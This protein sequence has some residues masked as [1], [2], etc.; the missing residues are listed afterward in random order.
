MDKKLCPY[1]MSEAVE[2]D[3]K[4]AAC[5]RSI[6]GYAPQP[7][8]LPPGWT[9]AGRYRLGR[10]LGEGGFGV[11][12]LEKDA[13]LEVK[14]AIKEYFPAQLIS[15]GP[16]SPEVVRYADA[17]GLFEK[18]RERFLQEARALA[19]ME[20][21]KEIVG[22]SGYF[23]ENGTAYIVM[24]LVEGETFTALAERQ[25][26]RM[27]GGQLLGLVEPLLLSLGRMHS[28]GLI[29]RDISPD[30][31]MLEDGAVR[32]LDMGSAKETLG[33][34]G[35]TATVLLKH[36]YAPLEQYLGREQGP[37]TDVYALCA[38]LYACLAGQPPPASLD[39]LAG[40]KLPP[41]RELGADI[42]PQQEQALLRGLA[43]KPRRRFL[44]MEELH[45][46]LYPE[47]KK[48]R[49]SS[50]RKAALGVG[51]SCG[52]LV[53]AVL[54]ACLYM[55]RQHVPSAAEIPASSAA[56]RAFSAPV[57]EKTPGG[58]GDEERLR[59]LLADSAAGGATVEAG[60][61]VM[62]AGPMTIEKPIRVEPG[63]VLALA[64]HTL[65]TGERRLEIEGELRVETLL[66]FTGKGSA[67]VAPG[68]TLEVNG[69]CWLEEEGSLAVDEGGASNAADSTHFFTVDEEAVFQDAVH[70]TNFVEY[71]EALLGRLGTSIVVDADMEI[72]GFG[73]THQMPVLI[74]E[75]VTITGAI[76]GT[77]ASS[78]NVD[79]TLLVNR[80]I[81]ADLKM[82]DWGG[83]G[84]PVTILNY[85]KIEGRDYLEGK[86]AVV[87]L[88]EMR[89]TALYAWATGLC[90]AGT[91]QNSRKPK[92]GGINI[93]AGGAFYNGGVCCSKGVGGATSSITVEQGGRLFNSGQM[94][95]G[96]MGWLTNE[97]GAEILSVGSMR[98]ED[99]SQLANP[100]TFYNAGGTVE[101]PLDENGQVRE[102]VLI[103]D[104]PAE[105]DYW[106][107]GR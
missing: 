49:P 103:G 53:L 75:G 71:R 89:V 63:A 37:W 16:G 102:S 11:T 73:E 64:G 14:V 47:S 15:R 30:N 83:R 36:S 98:F 51:A 76:Q 106:Q 35:R 70:V 74:S 94:D 81:Q 23:Q 6:A 56:A 59:A 80:G 43:L 21:L 20:K 88:G 12:Y 33:E 10:V 86:G 62:V 45:K 57:N 44:S 99:D 78:W 90:N 69:Y 13:L 22:V 79:G 24:E 55:L 17:D 66:Q 104:M 26:G 87:N 2:P 58:K 3:G 25:G 85:G 41:P 8:H 7:Y 18:G 28:L 34:G 101:L 60:T 105:A 48:K 31:L 27:P 100:G 1:C 96:N 5:G 77:Q 92:E 42:T 91:I 72:P 84:T 50:K 107:L 65:V 39:R 46:A 19:K 82:N 95:F 9:L 4:C 38:T 68:G 97:V 61:H 40:E 54:L 93:H 32:L 67:H 52:M 29:H